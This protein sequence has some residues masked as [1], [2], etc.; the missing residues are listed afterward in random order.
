MMH[1]LHVESSSLGFIETVHPGLWKICYNE[2]VRE[3]QNLSLK[4]D[5]NERNTINKISNIQ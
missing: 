4:R 5:F 3:K 1:S 2:Y